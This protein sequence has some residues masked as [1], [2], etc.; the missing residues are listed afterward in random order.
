MA[1]FCNYTNSCSYNIEPGK[2]IDEYSGNVIYIGASTSKIESKPIWQIK[3]IWQDGTIW[4]T[5]YP[6]GD[7]GFKFIWSDRL[8]YSYS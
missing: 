6:S 1:D 3:K 2:L 7:Q 4:R 8:S 5:D